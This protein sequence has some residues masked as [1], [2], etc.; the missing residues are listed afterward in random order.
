M[1]SGSWE[2]GST[3]DETSLFLQVL[4]CFVSGDGFREAE[5]VVGIV[6]ESSSIHMQGIH[7]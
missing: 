1:G 3:Y 4:E 7:V 2:R 6:L 5:R